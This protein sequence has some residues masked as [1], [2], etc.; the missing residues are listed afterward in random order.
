MEYTPEVVERGIEELDRV[1]LTPLHR[2]LI[3][4][5]PP[6]SKVLEVGCAAG[7]LSRALRQNG[8]DV[9]GVEQ[10]ERLAQMARDRVDRLIIGDFEQAA[11]RA[12]IPKDHSVILLADV[13]EHFAD[14]WAAVT[15]LR[16]MATADARWLITFPNVAHWAQRLNLLRGRWDYTD[17]G[18]MDRTHLRFF[19]LGTVRA[20]LAESALTFDRLHLSTVSYPLRWKIER[21]FPEVHRRLLDR[22]PNLLATQFLVE[23]HSSLR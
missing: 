5:V 8:C 6:G 2:T 15:T 21:H 1:G 13:I 11:V 16:E 9:T 10:V 3:N 19:A 18:L 22:F 17:F 7:H 4:L 23:A 12:Q 20:F 14:P